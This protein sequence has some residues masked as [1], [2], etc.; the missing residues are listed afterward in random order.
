MVGGTLTRASVFRVDLG[1]S[2]PTIVS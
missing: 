1:V 2:G